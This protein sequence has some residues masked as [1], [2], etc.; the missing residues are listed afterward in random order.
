MVEIDEDANPL[1]TSHFDVGLQSRLR[2]V[3]GSFGQETPLPLLDM[4]I[5]LQLSRKPTGKVS[6]LPVELIEFVN[7]SIHNGVEYKTIIQHLAENGH[8]GINKVNLARWRRSGHCQWLLARERHHAMRVRCDAAIAQARN[9]NTQDKAEVERFNED[10][11][12]NQ[13]ADTLAAFDAN[14]LQLER[15]DD[16]FKLVRLQTKREFGEIQRDRLALEA[17]KLRVYGKRDRN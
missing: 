11:V 7:Q 6:Q 12:A 9:M 1:S 4:E 14:N 3:T 2:R 13:I 16:F 17:K 8:P 15:P 5:K 10:L